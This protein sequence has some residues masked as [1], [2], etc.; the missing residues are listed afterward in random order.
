VGDGI[1][2][3]VHLNLRACFS[4]DVSGALEGAMKNDQSIVF[5]I[6]GAT[7]DLTSRKLLPALYNLFLDGWMPTRFKIVGLGRTQQSDDDFRKAMLTVLTT[8]LG[9]EKRMRISGKSFAANVGFIVSDIG[10]DKTYEDMGE[11]IKKAGQEWGTEP[12]IIYYLAVA[13]RFF[14]PIARIFRNII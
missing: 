1:L 8:I 5:F 6:F 4:P 3:F 10:E 7:G 9:G 11:C 13:P 12:C 2:S 14:E